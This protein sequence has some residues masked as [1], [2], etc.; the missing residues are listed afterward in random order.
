MFSIKTPAFII[1][2]KQIGPLMKYIISKT[3]I[4]IASREKI[5]LRGEVGYCLANFDQAIFW[6]CLIVSLSLN[7]SHPLSVLLGLRFSP[8]F[9]FSCLRKNLYIFHLT[10]SYPPTRKLRWP[11]RVSL[12]NMF[13]LK[14]PSFI[15]PLLGWSSKELSNMQYSPFN[16]CQEE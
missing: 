1:G 16:I 9:P 15:I 13:S 11:L 4:S 7:F 14:T 5:S 8:N 2:S 10:H 6:P 12:E 3:Q